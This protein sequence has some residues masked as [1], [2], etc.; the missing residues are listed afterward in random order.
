VVA[1]S[2][3]APVSVRDWYGSRVVSKSSFIVPN[4]SSSVARLLSFMYE[5][6][7]VTPLLP[8]TW[9]TARS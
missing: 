9:W 8:L 5:R 2:S 1:A 6:P 7:C 4:T 3:T